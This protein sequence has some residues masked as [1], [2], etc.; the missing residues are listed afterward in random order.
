MIEVIQNSYDMNTFNNYC[1]SY[2][3]SKQKYANIL[4]WE[5][6]SDRK[7]KGGQ[8]SKNDAFCLFDIWKLQ[9]KVS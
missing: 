9:K 3:P 7:H 5:I 1:T 2:P 8:K 4:S 6:Y